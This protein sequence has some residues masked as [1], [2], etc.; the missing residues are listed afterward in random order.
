MKKINRIIAILCV[1]ATV[2]SALVLSASAATVTNAKQTATGVKGGQTILVTTNKKWNSNLPGG[3]FNT[4]L[5]ITIPVY[6]RDL[7]SKEG[8]G[9]SKKIQVTTYKKTNRGWVLQNKLSGKFFCNAYSGLLSKSFRLPGKG[10][11]YKIVVTPE[12]QSAVRVP[13]DM[14]G[15][16]VDLSNHGTVDAVE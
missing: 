8:S 7:Y 3:F 10:A 14:V 13:A 5:K 12:Q 9:D 6:C 1:I 16:Q 11:Q 2:F 15:I 4:V